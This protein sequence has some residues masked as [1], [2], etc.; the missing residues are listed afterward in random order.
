MMAEDLRIYFF[1]F[2]KKKLFSEVIVQRSGLNPPNVYIKSC[3]V[4]KQKMI[5]EKE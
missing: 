3:D 5:K 1:F 4:F 2:K